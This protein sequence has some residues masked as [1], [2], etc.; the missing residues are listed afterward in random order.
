MHM[1]HTAA[2]LCTACPRITCSPSSLHTSD[3]CVLAHPPTHP[4][5]HRPAAIKE[6]LTPLVNTL[7]VRLL[8][9][10]AAHGRLPVKLGLTWRQGYGAP[11]TASAAAPTQLSTLL[12]PLLQAGTLGRDLLTSDASPGAT[13]EEAAGESPYNALL[14][15]GAQHMGTRAMLESYLGIF[16]GA[17]G[18]MGGNRGGGGLQVTRLAVSVMY[19]GE[20]AGS[21]GGAAGAAG[22]AAARGRLRQLEGQQTLQGF[23]K[24]Q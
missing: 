1:Q 18:A 5:T 22:G 9:T 8:D 7:W 11:R 24:S 17:A 2:L 3:T 15:P 16:R 6:A 13:G 12:R 21:G 10:T 23:R 19:G 14:S 20:A 4:P